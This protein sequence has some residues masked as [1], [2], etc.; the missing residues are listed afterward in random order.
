[1]KTET[2]ARWLT[3]GKSALAALVVVVI[4]NSLGWL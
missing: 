2:K 3:I 4:G 1:M